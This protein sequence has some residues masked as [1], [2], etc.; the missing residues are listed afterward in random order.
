M[1]IRRHALITAFAAAAASS[2][3]AAPAQPWREPDHPLLHRLAAAVRPAELQATLST[4]VGFG[5]RHTLSD[6]ASPARGV[7]A[8]ERWAAAQFQGFSAACDGCLQVVTPSETFTGARVPTPTAIGAVAAIQRGTTDPDR[9][10]LITAHIDSRVSDVMNATSDAPGANDDGSGVAAVMEAARILSRQRFPATV[11]YAVEAGEEQ[12]LYGAKAL[13]DYA[14]AHGWRVE[15]DLDNDIIGNTHGGDGRVV[16][17]R[18]RVFSEGTRQTET[19]AEI[20]QRQSTG[21]EVDSPSREVARFIAALA[22]RY[23]PGFRVQMIYR[24]DRFGRGGDQERFLEAGY[25]AVRLTEADENYTRQHQDLRQEN[26]VAYGDVASGVDIPYLARVTRV[27]VVALAA[28]AS[29]PPPPSALKIS[30]AVTPDTKLAWAATPGA[31]TYRAWWR[32]T[33]A[34]VWTDSRAAG[35]A[36][37]ITLP[38]VNIDNAL[39]G[40][41]AISADGYASP[42]EFP[43]LLGA[44]DRRSPAS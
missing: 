44:F 9:V 12:G 15:A 17:D 29:A 8:A 27:N 30:G 37:T 32:D 35:G 21:G 20:R 5:T 39:F 10:V 2:A 26:G 28:L 31:A 13:A 23:V 42:V 18:V 1:R 19:P 22:P 11:V 14:V 34:P 40:V 36:D 24:T 25:P 7:G 4:L 33:T 38:G 41:S 16:D 6:T 3:G 43:G